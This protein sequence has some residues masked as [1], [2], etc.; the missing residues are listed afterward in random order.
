MAK[1][2]DGMNSVLANQVHCDGTDTVPEQKM[3]TASEK[4]QHRSIIYMDMC[5]IYKLMI[6][7]WRGP[8]EQFGVT[9]Q[10]A[11]TAA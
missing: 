5:S 11:Y 9:A 6:A 4:L 3:R 1:E 7:L 8:C 2:F 10:H